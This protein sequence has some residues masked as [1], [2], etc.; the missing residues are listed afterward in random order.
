M[1][2]GPSTSKAGDQKREPIAHAVNVS[3]VA[4]MGAHQ[5]HCDGTSKPL[6]SGRGYEAPMVG[7]DYHP[8]GSQGKHR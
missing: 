6:Y 7:T 5:V 1:K 4:E 2:Q 8:H 3:T